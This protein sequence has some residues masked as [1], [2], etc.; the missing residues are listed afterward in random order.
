MGSSTHQMA[1]PDPV[2][3]DTPTAPNATSHGDAVAENIG[4]FTC[5]GTGRSCSELKSRRYSGQR[6]FAGTLSKRA[7]P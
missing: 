6:R 2:R 7:G 5:S 4:S 3:S 1:R